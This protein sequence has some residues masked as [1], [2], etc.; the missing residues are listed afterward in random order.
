MKLAA[1]YPILD[2]DSLDRRAIALETAAAVWLEAGASLM[3]IRHKGLWTRA[4]FDAARK[5]ARLCGEHGALCIVND[6]ADVAILLGAG[7]HVGQ[8]DLSPRD[9]RKLVGS[10]TVLG[11]STHNAPQL[12][13]AGGEPVDY[14]AFGPVFA[15]RS[16]AEADPVTGL[17]ELR[18]LRALVEKP[19]VAI[20]GIRRENARDV[21]EAGADS[22]A[23]IA[24]LLPEPCTP[25]ALR[26]RMEEWLR[27][28]AAASA[29]PK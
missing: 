13:A 25:H 5:V 23:V 2:A 8:E 21:L 14:V 18:R 20:G 26:E 10:E 11:Y 12:A 6:R 19:L 24:D 4:R 15:T 3:Q 17:E 16:K 22:L 1:L 27:V 9:A 29:V 28:V 7:L